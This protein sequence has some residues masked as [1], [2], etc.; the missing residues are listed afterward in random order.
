MEYCNYLAYQRAGKKGET[1][2]LR[3]FSEPG[4]YFKTA[5]KV[6]ESRGGFFDLGTSIKLS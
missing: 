1:M 5:I 3:E 4:L 6:F 2:A